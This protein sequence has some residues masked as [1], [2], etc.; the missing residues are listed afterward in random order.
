MRS[1]EPNQKSA[2]CLTR[3]ELLKAGLYGSA[4]A[5]LLGNLWLGGCSGKRRKEKPNVVFALVDTLRADHL[6][7]YGYKINTAP[8]IQNLA[9]S[10][11]LFERVIAPSSWTKTSMASIMTSQNPSRHGVRRGKDVLPEQ[12]ITMTEVFANNGYHTIGINTNPWLKSKFGFDV[13]FNSYESLLFLQDGGWTNALEV[14]AAAMAALAQRPEEKPFFLYLHYMDVHDPYRPKS[15]FY[16]ASSL[17]IPGHGVIPDAELER[18]YCDKGFDAP[19]VRN[20]VIELYNGGIRTVDAGIGQ[21]LKEMKK[22]GGLENTITVITSD[23][24][25]SFREH[26]TTKHGQNLYP[27]V[28]EVPL[29]FSWP[30]SLPSGVR[31][32]PQVCSIDI[33]PTLFALAGLAPQEGCDGKPL[34]PMR[35]DAIQCRIAKCAVGLNDASPDL[36][37]TAVVSAEHLYIREKKNNVVEFYDLK[38]DPGAQYN[39]GTLN[40]KVAAYA[41]LEDNAVSGITKQTDLDEKTIQQLKSLG[42]LR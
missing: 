15:P 2:R 18:L 42:Y 28:Y 26:G 19:G 22:V 12:L 33:A 34:L 30:G 7:S 27:E 20:R 36:D 38:L 17:T 9:E 41:K 25:E 16:S 39:L 1:S 37:Y 14:N 13:G 31:I 10:A 3:R 24:G 6:P 35:N 29:I 8:N 40:P 32:R 11:V 21:L 5:S 4:A 23:H